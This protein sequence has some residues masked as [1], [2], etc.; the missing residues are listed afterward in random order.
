LIS[1]S[2]ACKVTSREA[3]EVVTVPVLATVRLELAFVKTVPVVDVTAPAI[4]MLPNDDVIETLPAAVT[5]PVE[6]TV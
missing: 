6:A 2:A 4:D 1:P 3:A 5:D